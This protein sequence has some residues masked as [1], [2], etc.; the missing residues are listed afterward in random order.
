MSYQESVLNSK[1]IYCIKSSSEVINHR[2]RK[3]QG[4]KFSPVFRES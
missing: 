1:T 3:N 4:P 2:S